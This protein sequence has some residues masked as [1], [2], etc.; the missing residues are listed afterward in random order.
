MVKDKNIDPAA[1]VNEE[2]IENTLRPQKLTRFVGQEDLK[3]QLKIIVSAA[4]KRGEA[5]DHLLFY[6][7]DLASILTSLEHGDVLFIDEV[8]RLARNI[9][10][11]LYPAM[12]DFRLDIILGRGPAART[13]RLELEKFTIIAATTRIGL[14]SSPMR[15]RF[16]FVHR[17]DF[18]DQKELEQILTRSAT[19]LGID[20]EKD[21]A[22]EIAARSR[23]TPRIANRF[24]RRIRDFAQIEADGSIDINVAKN[25]LQLLSVDDKG[26]TK[27]DRLL[28]KTLAIKHSG[29][30]IGVETLAA[31]IN[32]DVGTIEEVYEPFL[33]QIGFL[34]RTPRGR[35]LTP[36]AF[37]F[38]KIP[39]PKAFKQGKLF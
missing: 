20:M 30:P 4:Q 3:Q 11:T 18:Y 26:L 13:L 5:L 2:N 22:S 39:L 10:E 8:H 25:A 12:E 1:Q 9:E 15:D 28:I 34:K 32:E 31:L 14:L 17:L 16:G 23:G 35:I 7:P 37:E 21:A 19:I 36:S 38:L 29:G 33:M 27:A 6:G 24:L